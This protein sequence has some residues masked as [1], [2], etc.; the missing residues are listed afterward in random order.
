M[1]EVTTIHLGRTAFTVAADAYA[2]LKSYLS[3]IQKWGGKDVAE[4]VE[5]RMAEL[6]SERGLGEQKVVLVRDVEYLR[7]QLGEPKDFADE[8]TATAAEE[9]AEPGES[10]RLYR[11]PENALFGGV[12]AGISAYFGIPVWVIRVAFIGLTFVGATGGL[13]YLLLWLLVPEAKTSSDR[14]HMQG[15][16]VTVDNLKELVERADVPGAARRG[17]TVLAKI[18]TIAGKILLFVVGLPLAIGTGLALVW[19][20]VVAVYYLLDGA[21]VAGEVVAPIGSH[22]VIAFIAGVVTLITILLAMFLVGVAMMR[23]RWQVPAWGVATLL[24]VFFVAASIGGAFAAD[25]V[26]HVRSR[27]E[28]LQH[29]QTVQVPAFTSAD[30]R[31]KDTRFIFIPDSQTYVQYHYFGKFDS[32]SIKTS[33][34]DNKLTVDT[35]TI[36]DSLNCDLFCIN[37]GPN[38]EIYIHAPNVQSITVDGDQANFISNHGMQQTAL[39][40][41]VGRNSLA[42]IE[43]NKILVADLTKANTGTT[44]QVSLTMVS[45]SRPGEGISMSDD[46]TIWLS[47]AG[48]LDMNASQTCGESEPFVFVDSIGTVKFGSQSLSDDKITNYDA[49]R[50]LDKPNNY[51]CLVVQADPLK[52]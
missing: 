6:L 49:L 36:T 20:V 16:A 46:G 42:S 28:A 13:L 17:S 12:A 21:K 5:L 48:E 38:L 39:S 43:N 37:S 47:G 27:V 41:T 34:Q 7:Q 11:D 10:K 19:T 30:L 4:E 22:E 14:L 29:S 35:G 50:N 8:D 23:R 32:K 40:L 52:Q 25:V 44:R 26:P 3:D 9:S 51:N 1:N 2:K 45:G 33:V 15:K 18:L 31:G 24:G